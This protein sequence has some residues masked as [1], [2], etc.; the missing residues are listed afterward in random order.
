MGAACKG[1]NLRSGARRRVA[2]TARKS[3][4]ATSSPYIRKIS[5]TEKCDPGPVVRQ[6]EVERVMGIE[7]TLVAWEATVLPLN[8]TRWPTLI[9][10]RSRRVGKSPGR[11]QGSRRYNAPANP[12]SRRKRRHHDSPSP[13][14]PGSARAAHL[15]HLAVGVR[16]HQSAV[17]RPGRRRACRRAAADTALRHALRR[18]VHRVDHRAG[19][20]VPAV[21]RR[22]GR[23]A[24]GAVVAG[25]PGH[26]RV[27]D[28]GRP[29]PGTQHHR[30]AGVRHAE[31]HGDRGP[32]GRRTLR[33]ARRRPARRAQGAREPRLEFRTP[34]C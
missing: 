31:P 2:R 34:C 15:R 13:G 11:P 9:L 28:R 6:I 12:A 30:H 23:A 33:P 32:L 18:R 27:H 5:G 16:R 29:E 22:S 3:S 14:V 17:P 8:Y 25:V 10:C 19:R 24:G 7:P 26:Q 1:W 20:R 21:H 4:D